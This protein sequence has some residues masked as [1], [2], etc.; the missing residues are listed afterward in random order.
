VHQAWKAE[1][2]ALKRDCAEALFLFYRLERQGGDLSTI[3]TKEK[4]REALESERL[5]LFFGQ[6]GGSIDR[7][8]LCSCVA[9]PRCSRLCQ[10]PVGLLWS[11]LYLIVE[12]TCA[13]SR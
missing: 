5:E 2:R 1:V 11:V 13:L 8:L 9:H 3:T 4:I 12:G 7:L 6:V 10:P